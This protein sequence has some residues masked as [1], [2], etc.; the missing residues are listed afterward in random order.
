MPLLKPHIVKVDIGIEQD[1]AALAKEDHVGEDGVPDHDIL[2]IQQDGALR[3][4]V[5]LLVRDTCS[6]SVVA[7]WSCRVN[8][9]ECCCTHCPGLPLKLLWRL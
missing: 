9:Y 2:A 1:D 7:Q 5:A 3:Q 8:G 6:R 4:I